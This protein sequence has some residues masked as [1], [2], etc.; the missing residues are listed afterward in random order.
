MFASLFPDGP[1]AMALT[2]AQKRHLRGLAH[3]LKPVVMLGNAGFSEGVANELELTLEHHELIKVRVTAEDRETRD[4]LI[5]EMCAT[6]N[7]ELVQ[8]IGHIAVIYRRAKKP[9][10]RLS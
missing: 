10:I 3:K 9:T 2:Q 7:C 1:S 4:A 6:V 5:K 8:R